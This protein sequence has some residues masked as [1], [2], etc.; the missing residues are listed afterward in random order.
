MNVPSAG[1]DIGEAKSVVTS[2]SSEGDVI[3]HFSYDMNDSGWK[4]FTARIPDSMRIVFEASGSAYPVMH[5]LRSLG[6]RDITVAHP[7]EL[8]WIVKSKHKNDHV[9][10]VKL[11]KLHL[12][13]MI[14]ESH[15]LDDDERIFRDLLIQR[16]K[17]GKQIGNLKSSIIGYLKREDLFSRLPE[18]VDNFSIKRREVIR[19]IRFDNPKD[20]VLGTMMDRLE[21]LEK[22]Q[23]TLEKSIKGLSR[24]NDDV[25]LLMTIPGINYY[26]AALLSSYIGDI[27]RFENDG[28]LASFFGV[29]PSNRDSS[30]MVR[31]GRMSKEGPSAA[32]WALSIAVD[33]IAL[34]NGKMKEYYDR[35][36]KQSGS[37]KLA[38]VYTM[39]KLVSMIHYMLSTRNAWKYENEHLTKSKLRDLDE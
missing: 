2:I 36:K 17:T 9:D 29:V 6:Y 26:L 32:R 38:H 3:E 11:A 7:K 35:K 18:S 1:I 24:V 16:L 34:Y 39:R 27:H 4:E 10:S 14:P 15:L 5:K 12:V 23:T 19:A 13:G 22:Q 30:S 28:K 37:G 8:S 33:T 25:R 21:F 20:L 31:R